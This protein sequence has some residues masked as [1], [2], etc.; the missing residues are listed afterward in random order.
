LVD[1]VVRFA[2]MRKRRARLATGALPGHLRHA[3]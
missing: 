2:D 1:A 3:A